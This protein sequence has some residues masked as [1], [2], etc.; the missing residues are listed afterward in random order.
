M[1]FNI[2]YQD[3]NLLV[4][5]KSPNVVVFSENQDT[6]K[7]LIDFLLEQFPNLKSAGKYPRHGIVHRLDKD[8]SG[9]LLVAKNSKTLFFLQEQFKNR[10]VIK[11]YTALV[12]GAVKENQGKIETLVGRSP[13]NR[14]KQKVYLPL[15]PGSKGKRK[16]VTRYKVLKRFSD[17]SGKKYTLLEV[18]PETGRKHQIRTHLSYLNHPIA[19]DKLYG[20]KN[21]SFTKSLKRQFLHASFLEIKLLDGK[22]KKFK[23]E[24]PQDLI[25]AL[26]E[27]NEHSQ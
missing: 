6:Q 9:I 3:D 21:E 15:E 16:A 22:K 26:E 7:T 27:L 19:G 2:L 18:A 23:S 10:E 14:I 1:K 12:V 20:F 13:K 5:D 8:T 4:I 17:K 11:K 25:R 24:L